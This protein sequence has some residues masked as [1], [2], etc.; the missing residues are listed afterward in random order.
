M[1]N[2][3]ILQLA[4]P[5]IAANITVPLVGMVDLAIAGRLHETYFIAGISLGSMVFDMLYWNFAFL[6]LGTGGLTAQAYGRRDLSTTANILAQSLLVSL[7]GAIIILAV[8]IP[9]MKFTFSIVTASPEATLWAET[10]FYIRV[11][12]APATVSLFALKGWFIGMQNSLS[13]MLVD[14]L[15]NF[16][17]VGLSIALALWL[18]M[19]VAGIAI[20]TVLSQYLGL[21]LSIFFIL[22][23]YSK[24][25]K[26]LDVKKIFDMK[27]IKQYFSLNVNIFIR[28]LLLLLIYTT[29]TSFSSY[30]G[31]DIL[32]TNTILLKVTMLY[33]FVIDG[34]AYA[35][36]ALT[37]RYI[38]GKE[39][40]LLRK[41]VKSV[42]IWSA[43]IVFCSVIF[44]II[45]AESLVSWLADHNPKIVET[46]K[47]YIAWVIFLPVAS[48]VAF[49][50]DSI[51]IGA[52]SSVAMRNVVLVAT[53]CY[54]IIYGC[55]YK[56]LEVH[57]LWL[58]FTSSMVIRSIG[59][60]WYSKK[61]VF[62]KVPIPKS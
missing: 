49:L 36:E 11:W 42:F 9:V 7:I 57:A 46:S 3:R 52:T 33:V 60:Q 39:P 18:K 53:I 48:S 4:L 12:A 2:K 30:F 22:R 56:V 27:G 28:S 24:L 59:M 62:A 32:S 37:G 20:G 35:G 1:I 21:G 10:Y 45:G 14:L 13:P 34:F 40:I 31:D 61:S 50:W 6:R 5:S 19:G 29:F 41:T 17:N 43:A 51:F 23:F 26:Y 55:T 58:A 25:K 15:I 38:G 44:Y 16:A 47:P 8:Q 54:F